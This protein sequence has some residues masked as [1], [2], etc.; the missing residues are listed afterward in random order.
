LHVEDNYLFL[1]RGLEVWGTVS[2]YRKDAKGNPLDE[3]GRN[4]GYFDTSN[5]ALDHIYF[6]TLHQSEATFLYLGQQKIGSQD[7]YVVAFAQN[8][9]EASITIAMEGEER[10]NKRYVAH[11]LV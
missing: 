11:L 5:F 7:A 1:R 2:E 10:P 6:A 9:G 3:I 4:K 8:P